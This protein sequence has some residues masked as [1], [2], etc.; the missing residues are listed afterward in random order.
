MSRSNKSVAVPRDRITIKYAATYYFVSQF[1]QYV[2]RD[3]ILDYFLSDYFA[4]AMLGYIRP[5][6][7]W[8]AL[9][10]FSSLY[11]DLVLDAD[12]DRAAGLQYVRL[13]SCEDESCNRYPRSNAHLLAVDLCR[14]HKHDP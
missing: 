11:A 4:D 1:D 9:H 8:T 14:I 10:K 6:R 5:F 12:F 3:L 13:G 7:K 2:N